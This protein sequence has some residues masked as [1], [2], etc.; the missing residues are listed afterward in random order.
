MQIEAWEERGIGVL[1]GKSMDGYI[2]IGE[3]MTVTIE[4]I[5]L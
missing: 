3:T 2:T 5:I 4:L 1:R